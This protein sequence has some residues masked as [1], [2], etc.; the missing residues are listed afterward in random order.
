MWFREVENGIEGRRANIP[1]E[2]ERE[3]E[4]ASGKSAAE[5]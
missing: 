5:P 3:M 1:R 4:S 2:G